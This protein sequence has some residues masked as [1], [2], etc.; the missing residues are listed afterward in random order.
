[1]KKGKETHLWTQGYVCAVATLINLN[2]GV[3]TTTKEL[4]HAGIGSTSLSQLKRQGVD[5]SDLA[6]LKKFWK[7][8]K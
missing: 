6:V 1:M 2:G 7:E 8:L 5:E 3:D 4:F